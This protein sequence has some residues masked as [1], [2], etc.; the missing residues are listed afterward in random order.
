MPRC[1]AISFFRALFDVICLALLGDSKVSKTPMTV[2]FRSSARVARSKPQ[3]ERN[4][5]P[6]DVA[7]SSLDFRSVVTT[8]GVEV[9]W[10]GLEE[11]EST[12]EPASPVFR[13]APAL[14]RRELKVRRL[15]TDQKRGRFG[16]TKYQVVR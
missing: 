14:L 4:R 11:T 2:R 9:A 10:E 12:W 3:P 13:D 15:K 7:E 6:W 16:P 1:C 5:L 8:T